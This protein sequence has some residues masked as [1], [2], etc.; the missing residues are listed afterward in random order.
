MDRYPANER[1]KTEALK[2]II[3]SVQIRMEKP[4]I[5]KLRAVSNEVVRKIIN[6]H[7]SNKYRDKG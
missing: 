3:N 6:R 4:E 1:K 5:F 2:T 7:A